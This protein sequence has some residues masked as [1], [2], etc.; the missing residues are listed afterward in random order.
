VGDGTSPSDQ[1]TPVPVAV[2]Q[3]TGVSFSDIA[4]AHT[5]TCALTNVGQA[6]CWGANFYGQL[7]DGTT[8]FSVAPAP[9]AVVF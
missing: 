7:G 9:V 2:A 1:P 6:L 5:H 4:A 8:N 3:S